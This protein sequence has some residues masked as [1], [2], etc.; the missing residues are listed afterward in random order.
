MDLQI[1]GYGGRRIAEGRAGLT[2]LHSARDVSEMI[3]HCFNHATRLVL[4]DAGNG[5]ASDR[6]EDP[7]PEIGCRRIRACERLALYRRLP[8]AGAAVSGWGCRLACHRAPSLCRIPVRRG[9]RRWA[10]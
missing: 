8:S 1:H 6:L 2:L 7:W 10:L 9:G 4:L 5:L 3:E